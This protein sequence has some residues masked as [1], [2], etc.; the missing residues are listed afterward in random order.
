MAAALSLS[1][2]LLSS[3]T[4]LTDAQSISGLGVSGGSGPTG[5][6]GDRHHPVL[7]A[8]SIIT[9]ALIASR[10]NQTRHLADGTPPVLLTSG[11]SPSSCNPYSV[12]VDNSKAGRQQEMV[13]FG[14]AVTDSTVSVFDE[15]EPAVLHQLMEDLFGQDGNNM[16]FMRHTIGSSDLSGDQ[17]SYDDNGNGFN[18]GRPDPSLSHFNLTADGTA[19]ARLLA[20]MGN[21]KGD[22]FLFGSSWSLPGWMKNNEL[23]IA[24]NTGR[25]ELNNSLN[26]QYIPSAITYFTKYV[27][28]FKELGVNINGLTLQ[29]EPLNYPGGYPTM[30]L[31]AADEAAIISQGLGLAM[32]QRGVKLMAYDHNT[33]QPAYPDRVFQG[34]NGQV[35]MVSWH[36]YQSP[37]ADYTVLS[38][39]HNLYPNAL[40]FMTECTSYLPYPGQYS[41]WV[42]QHFISPV[43]NGASGGSFWVLG[44]DPNYGPKSPYGGCQGCQGSIIVNSSTTYTKTHDYYMIGQFSRYVRRGGVN[45]H[46]KTG[47][48]GSQSS[49]Q[50][51]I[52]AVQNPDQSWAVIFLNTLGSDQDVVLSFTEGG[53][54]WEGTVPNLAVTTWLL[55]AHGGS[56]NGNSSSSAST[57][58]S[59]TT[60]T[61]ASLSAFS[62]AYA[63][64]SASVSGGE[65]RAST[66]V[67]AGGPMKVKWARGNLNSTASS[68]TMSGLVLASKCNAKFSEITN[69]ALS[70]EGSSDKEARDEVAAAGHHKGKTSTTFIT[71]E[72]LSTTLAGAEVDA[73]EHHKGK[74][75]T[76]FITLEAISTTLAGAEVD[77]AEHHKGK[78][79]TTFITFEAVPTA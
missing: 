28:A 44:T 61:N 59:A 56:Q 2:F 3:F 10:P 13:G 68:S 34:T 66:V 27:D 74:T 47:W 78:T 4:S 9:D 48:Q 17:Y 41:T 45:Y 35:D 57:S 12:V 15:L 5:G 73:A 71:L 8:Q 50:F 63:G 33:D 46:I 25:N 23:L 54:V 65:A 60:S 37:V 42:A 70:I 19:M 21:Y 53:Q 58:A 75:S 51:Y 52:M 36:C 79:S 72:A 29:N 22:V 6:I 49:D 1:L 76:T 55:P 30:Y 62:S 40:Q 64:A 24:P 38:D 7:K 67:G 18:Q 16:G 31:D 11:G 69:T 14:H 39:F 43:R 26:L 20:L 77:A 32:A